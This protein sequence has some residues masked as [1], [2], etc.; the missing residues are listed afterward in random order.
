[1]TPTDGQRPR[2]PA[3][4]REQL[5]R[6]R[7][8]R[9]TYTFLSVF[10]MMMVVGLVAWGNWQS[11]WTIGGTAQATT[12][13]CPIQTV[14]D[15][16]LTDITVINGTHRNGLAAA[17]AKELQKRQF[18]VMSIE[19]EALPK[20]L[21]S[22]VMVRYGAA[23]KLAA[24]TVAMQFP[25]KIAMV[26]DKRDSE[27]IDVVIGEKYKSMVNAKKAAAAIKQKSGSQGCLPSTPAA[28]DRTP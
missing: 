5:V 4:S 7:Q 1:M 3:Q 6:A 13:M 15:P 14:V 16:E 17:V 8:R 25:A 20:P 28:P 12:V 26:Q 23:G 18:R 11:W 27:A 24:H 21:K 19:T 22:V 9:Q 10:M 2:T